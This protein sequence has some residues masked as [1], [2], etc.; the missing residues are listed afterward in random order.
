M[1]DL[2]IE[3]GKLKLMVEEEEAVE[4][5]EQASAKKKEEIELSL[6]GNYLPKTMSTSGQ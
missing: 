3:W 5:E 6:S 4:F 1:E 2:E